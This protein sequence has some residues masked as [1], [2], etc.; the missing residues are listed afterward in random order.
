MRLTIAITLAASLALTACSKK[1]EAADDN[2][3]AVEDVVSDADL[4]GVLPK[5]GLYRSSGELL[6]IDIPGVAATQADMFGAAFSEGLAEEITYCVTKDMTGPDYLSKLVESK[7]SIS[8]FSAEGG[9]VDA[10]LSCSGGEGIEGRATMRGTASPTG[11]KMNVTFNQPLP[12]DLQA[13]ISMT[14]TA[15]RIG[16]CP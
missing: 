15:Q 13:T 10:V 6:S 16:D 4:A 11:S 5:P 2:A 14:T 9:E 8:R 12:G 1:D 7:C 3:L